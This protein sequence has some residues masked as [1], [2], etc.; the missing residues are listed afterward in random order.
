MTVGHAIWPDQLSQA[1]R[2]QLEPGVPDKLDRA[3]DVLIVGGGILGCA[4]AA[5]CIRAGRGSIVLIERER[6]GAG[7]TGGAAGLLMPEEH[8]GVDP[9]ELVNLM[10]LSLARWRELEATWPGG[11]GLLPLREREA[12]VNPLRAVARLAAG[13]PQVAS[14]VE[15]R[16][17]TIL[18]SQI[19][20]VETN[21]GTFRPRNVIFTT[22]T[23]PRLDG[24][25]LNLPA[26]EVKGHMLASHPTDL[27]PGETIA[28]TVR[29]IEQ[30]RILMGGTLDVG[31]NERV[32]RPEVGDA[33]WDELAGLWPRAR[34]IAIEYR[35]ACFR[36]A[37]PDLM[38]VIDR[39][40][41]VSNAWL[42]S[43]H[44]RTGILLAPATG[45]ALAEW[46]ATG[47]PPAEVK[48][49]G[50]ARLLSAR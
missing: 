8:A 9:P 7:P 45:R 49:F 31:D 25:A 13:L 30:G 36:P 4:T 44:Y 3:P 26:S 6:L 40:P 22:G 10:R 39:V 28:D 11:V 20:S 37:H 24:L 18:D 32:V 47:S 23:P 1:E 34:D 38:P 41:G 2:A 42:T 15:A 14:G 33:M 27:R 48:P 50:M 43:G 29:V 5:A 12:R 16:A 46:M 21:I 19:A 35:W 17:V